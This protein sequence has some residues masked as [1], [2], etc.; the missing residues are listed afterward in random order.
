MLILNWSWAGASCLGPAH[1]QLKPAAMLQNIPNQNMLVFFNRF[2]SYC[3]PNIPLTQTLNHQRIS[4]TCWI[5]IL[6]L[7]PWC[8]LRLNTTSQHHSSISQQSNYTAEVPS[9]KRPWVSSFSIVPIKK[10]HLCFWNQEGVQDTTALLHHPQTTQIL[11]AQRP[12]KRTDNILCVLKAVATSQM[13]IWTREKSASIN[14][15][16][17]SIL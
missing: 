7:L 3:N 16:M 17:L 5:M 9:S 12:S 13:Q 8:W 6:P 10:G 2:D 15:P 14:R 4:T 1:D 11:H